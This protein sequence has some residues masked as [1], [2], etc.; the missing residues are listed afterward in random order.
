MVWLS[1]E[2]ESPRSRRMVGMNLKTIR[3][4]MQKEPKSHYK[5]ES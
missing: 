4:E 2:S 3:V 5:P 1:S